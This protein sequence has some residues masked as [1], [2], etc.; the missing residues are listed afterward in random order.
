MKWGVRVGFKERINS[1]LKKENS[2]DARSDNRFDRFTRTVSKYFSAEPEKERVLRYEDFDR[3]GDTY[4]ATVSAW[5]KVM[6]R[7]FLLCLAVFASVSI[8]VNFRHITYDNFFYLIKDFETAVDTENLGYET[9]S[10][11][12]SSNQSFSLYRGGLA[13]VGRTNVSAFTA[14]GRRTLN[15]RDTYSSPFATASDKYLLVCDM[16]E[17]NLAVYNSFSKIYSEKLSYPITSACFSQSGEFAVLTRSEKYESQIIV[18]DNDFERSVSFNRGSYAIDI[19]MSSD[20]EYLGAVYLDTEDGIACTS[21]VFYDTRNKEKVS[22]YSY[23]GEFP[24]ACT[25]FDLGSF[26]LITDG[27]LRIFDRALEEKRASDT[28]ASMSVSGFF[29]SSDYAAVA[30]NDGMVTDENRI[31][32]FDKKGDLVYNSSVNSEIGQLAVC[33]GHIFIKNDEG[34]LRVSIDKNKTEQLAC[35]EGR[36]L[37]YD[38]S[39][40]LV[41]SQAKAAYLKFD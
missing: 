25:F 33:E 19:S 35:S 15:A 21:V 27:S 8:A 38:G 5:Y 37:A 2:D 39:T 1:F 40:V 3:A 36:M 30:F 7:V 14:T 13:V 41:C 16:G 18:Y 22:E 31:F 6:Q 11:D 24:L 23:S 32:V 10:Y 12:A 34:V 4:Y 29:D 17:G 26:A 9:L 28:Y 20:G